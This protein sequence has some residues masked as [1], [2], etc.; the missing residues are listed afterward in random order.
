VSKLPLLQARVNALSKE[1]GQGAPIINVVLPNNLNAGGY[2]VY[3]TVPN[4]EP[5]VAPLPQALSPAVDS[6]SYLL[7]PNHSEGPKMDIET[8]CFFISLSEDLLSHF[9][10]HRISGTHAFA[11]ISTKELKEMD[12]KI[13]EIIDI[14]EAVKEWSRN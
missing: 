3:P 14:K 7:P 2:P 13:G 10:E 5:P 4:N 11:H 6:S 9:R 12:F 1:R 8:F